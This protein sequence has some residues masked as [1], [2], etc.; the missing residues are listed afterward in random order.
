MIKNNEFDSFYGIET[1]MP[2]QEIKNRDCSI[3][4]PSEYSDL[5]KIFDTLPLTPYD[6]IVDYGCGLG[7]V[8]F[9]CNQRFM[10]RVTG[11]E[12]DKE[13]Y[14]RLTDN[15]EIYFKR[16]RNQETKFSLLHMTAEEYIIEP[17]DNYFYFFN[18]FSKEIL[19]NVFDKITA[20]YTESPRPITIIF[21]YCTY[22]MMSVIRNYSF[23]LKSIIKLG[24]YHDDPDDKAYIYT[25]GA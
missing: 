5:I 21:Y 7:R 12:Y 18:P 20:S 24:N 6:T 13:I 8:L 17:T 14:D 1:D 25:L 2:K 9:Y 4:E 10:C 15:A 23:T 19:H 3:Y 22:D 11:V 16:F